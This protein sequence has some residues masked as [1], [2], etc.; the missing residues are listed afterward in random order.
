LSFEAGFQSY[1]NFDLVEFG[2]MLA[3]QPVQG[4]GFFMTKPVKC[5]RLFADAQGESH[6]EEIEFAMSDVQYAPPAPPL[7]LS[8]PVTATA[9]RW[10]RFPTDWNDAAHPSPRRQ[11]FVVLSGEVEGWTSTG[12][13]M[14]FRAGDR[15]L[16]EDTTG[17]G[18]GA[19]PIGGEALAIMI[20]LE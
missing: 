14:V 6:I 7:H 1:L 11:L 20:A 8:E 16:M 4:G 12:Q 17:K 5:A 9:F 19:K 10:L 3:D 18:H 13:T 2:R 15:L